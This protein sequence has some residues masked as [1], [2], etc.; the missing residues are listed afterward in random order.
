MTDRLNPQQYIVDCAMNDPELKELG[1]V[2]TKDH[3]DI[4][5][6]AAFDLPIDADQ[7]LPA[8]RTKLIPVIYYELGT[9]YEDALEGQTIMEHVFRIDCRAL[10]QPKEGPHAPLE[11]YAK[12]EGIRKALVACLRRGGR[13]AREGSRFDAYEPGLGVHGTF[14]RIQE[15]AI[16]P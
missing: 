6:G 2:V 14:R 8:K 3:S 16:E 9:D 13:L 7:I 11:G 12:A 15:I 1:V 5:P 10:R 4:Q